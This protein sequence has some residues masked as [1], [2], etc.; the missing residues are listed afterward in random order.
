MP[1]QRY[2]RLFS[3]VRHLLTAVRRSFASSQAVCATHD[4]AETHATQF[5]LSS[6]QP[7]SSS[8]NWWT[9]NSQCLDF[10]SSE[11]RLVWLDGLTGGVG[12]MDIVVVNL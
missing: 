2:G 12:A 3:A 4:A 7:W 6:I 9:S 1:Q 10:L 11:L 5:S 8:S